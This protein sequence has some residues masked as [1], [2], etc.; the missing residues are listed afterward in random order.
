MS[1]AIVVTET[2]IR[3]VTVQRIGENYNSYQG[4]TNNVGFQ[5]KYNVFKYG[6]N[7]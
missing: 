5:I 3:N 6:M 7:K 4:N 1:L 2:H